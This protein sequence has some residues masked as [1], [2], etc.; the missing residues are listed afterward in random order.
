MQNILFLLLEGGLLG[1][2]PQ[3]TYE[4]HEDINEDT[5]FS[6]HGLTAGFGSFH[7]VRP[8]STAIKIE[9]KIAPREKRQKSPKY[10]S[11]DINSQNKITKIRNKLTHD[12]D[13]S[14]IKNKIAPKVENKIDPKIENKIAP[15]SGKVTFVR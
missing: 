10:P 3:H 2:R 12:D 8:S 11:V 9:N 4:V 6:W 7:G 14:K 5:S 1:N 15:R 13:S